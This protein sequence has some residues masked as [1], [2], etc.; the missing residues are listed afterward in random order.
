MNQAKEPTA[1][2]LRQLYSAAAAFRRAE[3]WQ[4]FY[5]S[6]LIGGVENPIDKTIGYCSVMGKSGQHFAL[7]VFWAKRVC[8]ALPNLWA[9]V[10]FRIR[11]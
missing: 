5:D 9:A 7:G 6:D 8:S 11:R 3:P 10:K 2:Q 1:N 4:T